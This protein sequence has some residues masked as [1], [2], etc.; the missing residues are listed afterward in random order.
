MSRHSRQGLCHW[1]PEGALRT[2]PSRHGLKGLRRTSTYRGI[3][4]LRKN[5]NPKEQ[6][7]DETQRHP[8]DKAGVALEINLFLIRHD[9]NMMSSMWLCNVIKGQFTL[10]FGA[11]SDTLGENQE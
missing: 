11:W 6:H 3:R 10:D 1:V 8:D 7:R 9:K 5:E 2:R 4:E